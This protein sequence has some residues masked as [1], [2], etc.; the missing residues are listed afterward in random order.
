MEKEFE[1]RRIRLA[2]VVRWTE[3]LAGRIG[4]GGRRERVR[5]GADSR[6]ASLR[7]ESTV[8]KEIGWRTGVSYRSNYLLNWPDLF[9]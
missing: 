2:V 9:L 3:G 5:V 8:E 7:V 4:E 6:A 1:L